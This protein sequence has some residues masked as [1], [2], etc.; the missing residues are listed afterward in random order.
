M[1]GIDS[2]I[3]RE[4]HEEY[5]Q[6]EAFAVVEEDRLETLP[7]AF[8]D[9]TYLFK[10]CEWVVRWYLRRPLD[11][12]THEAETAFR[13]NR[14]D[15]IE[16]AID[17]AITGDTTAER[18]QS[19]LALDGV[20]VRIASAFLQFIDPERFATVA[21]P[22][23]KALVAAGDLDVPYPDPVRPSDYDRYLDE[24]REYARRADCRVVDVGRALWRI[25]Q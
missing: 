13:T 6:R 15:A 14:M 1:V 17:G 11:G 7:G 18:L 5:L 2:E 16:T 20:D 24:C 23:W 21:A 9:G 4:R 25:G 8:R 22:C 10:D 3:I 12:E 19:L